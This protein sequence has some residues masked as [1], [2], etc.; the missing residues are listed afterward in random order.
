M[1]TG[2]LDRSLLK[3]WHA[4]GLFVEHYGS[5][6]TLWGAG[7]PFMMKDPGYG[8]TAE[9][10]ATVMPDILERELENVMGAAAR[11]ILRFKE[12]VNISALLSYNFVNRSKIIFRI[13][14]FYPR[15]QAPNVF[16]DLFSLD[17]IGRRE[18]S[19]CAPIADGL[20]RL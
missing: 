3:G 13:D 20:V 12:M 17:N 14:P 11:R 18:C 8:K 1:P 10:I 2:A 6:H 16:A 7:F 19:I 4:P 9:L 5:D 15:K